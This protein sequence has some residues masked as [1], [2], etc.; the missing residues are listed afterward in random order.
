MR[1][2]IFATVVAVAPFL[3]SCGDQKSTMAP[4]AVE[5]PA[6]TPTKVLTQQ[7]RDSIIS[8]ATKGL[9]LERDKI[10]KIS[11]YKTQN[12]FPLKERLS[13]Y[14]SLPDGSPPIFRIYIGY[15]GKDWIFFNRVKVMSD[16]V[17]VYEKNFESFSVKRDNGGSYVW[18]TI[19]YAAHSSDLTAIRKI[20]VAKK[21]IIRLSGDARREDHDLTEREVK[22]IKTILNVFDDLSKLGTV[23]LN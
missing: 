21:S 3:I 10:E 18:E 22:N 5:K 2:S 13:A 15:F 23:E 19:D 7:E 9:E 20:A 16:D 14:I 17:V 12:M 6:V 4:T 1:F 11:F 8:E